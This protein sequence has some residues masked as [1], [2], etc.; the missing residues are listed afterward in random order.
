MSKPVTDFSGLAPLPS[1]LQVVSEAKENQVASMRGGPDLPTIDDKTAATK[2]RFREMMA[3]RPVPA[4][5]PQQQKFPLPDAAE[6]KAKLAAGREA[7]RA[8]IAARNVRQ[9]AYDD[10]MHTLDCGRE[11]ITDLQKQIEASNAID[12]DIA[13]FLA[14]HVNA[15]LLVALV[16]RRV[17]RDRIVQKHR[18]ACAAAAVL[19]QHAEAAQTHLQ[20]AEDAVRARVQS[21]LGYYLETVAARLLAEEYATLRDRRDI[22][23]AADSG[24]VLSP[25]TRQVLHECRPSADRSAPAVRAARVQRWRALMD[26]LARD[27]NA[28]I[29]IDE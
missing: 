16:E 6:A 21:V 25:S 22:V 8:S 1:H 7:L 26:A 19:E 5:L 24:I 28:A 11:A 20:A 12:A 18:D 29:A 3:Q 10:A 4:G 14:G 2:L 9:S 15:D 17:E 23:D 13:N 27:A